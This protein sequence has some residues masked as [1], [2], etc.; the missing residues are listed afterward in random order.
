MT[1]Y[2][3]VV[4]YFTG[5]TRLWER[6]WVAS[7]TVMLRRWIR[8]DQRA[9]GERA[10]ELIAAPW[11][12][13][14]EIFSFGNMASRSS[15]R[16]ENLPLTRNVAAKLSDDKDDSRSFEAGK[17]KSSRGSLGDKARVGS[18]DS[19]NRGD[20]EPQLMHVGVGQLY[21]ESSIFENMNHREHIPETVYVDRR[22]APSQHA[23]APLLPQHS[24]IFTSAPRSDV[25]SAI[26]KT[27]AP[28]SSH[29]GGG[30]PSESSLNLNQ[31]VIVPSDREHVSWNEFQAI[32][33]GVSRERIQEVWK[34][35]PWFRTP[36]PNRFAN[37]AASDR[38]SWNEFQRILKGKGKEEIRN[39][40]YE[41]TQGRY[42]IDVS[43]RQKTDVESSAAD[44]EGAHASKRQRESE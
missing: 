3:K 38:V 29:F 32:N 11:P 15:A 10:A 41:Y 42:H 27:P 21:N 31:N 4:P 18:S 2:R 8:L 40:W 7:G 26:I 6:Q 20:V 24:T 39:L 43:S 1:E 9:G 19:G 33:K 16:L 22:P 28:A 17:G 5:T 44:E 23:A 36:D 25:N 12:G 34:T 13:E 37:A 35:T 14:R 30:T